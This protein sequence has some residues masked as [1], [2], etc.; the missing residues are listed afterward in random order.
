MRTV[1]T[2]SFAVVHFSVAFTVA[3]AVTGS[4]AVGGMVALIEPLVNTL[5]YYLHEVIWDMFRR[6]TPAVSPQP[7]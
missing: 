3:Y 7:A 6:E 4:L 1:K 2:L 5:A